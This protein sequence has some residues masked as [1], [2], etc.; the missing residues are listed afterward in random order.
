[1]ITDDRPPCPH[2]ELAVGWAFHCLEP[3]EESQFSKHLPGCEECRRAVAQAE[4]VGTAMAFAA[5]DAAPRPQ[6]RQRVLAVAEGSN[7]GGPV[8][9]RRFARRRGG[10]MLAVAAA[11]VLIAVSGFLGTWLVQLDAERDRLAERAEVMSEVMERIAEP[12]TASAALV[13][14]DGKVQAVLILADRATLVPVDLPP[15]DVDGESYVFWGV[16]AHGPV[17]LDSFDVYQERA[18]VKIVAF[19]TEGRTFTAFALSLEPG[20]QLPAE[21]SGV[22]ASG[23][24]KR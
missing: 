2:R 20:D 21:P 23:K 3:A 8:D 10:T 11:V 22:I 4:D 1:M 15:N 14:D 16:G 18:T 17:A 12:N 6:L 19:R 9:R 7:P 5:P 13:N 24:V